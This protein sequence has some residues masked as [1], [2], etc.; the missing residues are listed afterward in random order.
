MFPGPLT[1]AL[2]N[3][4]GSW[5][6][7]CMHAGMVTGRLVVAIVWIHV[8]VGVFVDAATTKQHLNME[9]KVAIGTYEHNLLVV[10][11]LYS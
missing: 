2:S 4:F 5:C 9:S 7:A 6:V 10:K 3:K 11:A 1:W 8:L